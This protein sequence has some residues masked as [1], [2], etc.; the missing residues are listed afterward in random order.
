ML[1]RQ[2]PLTWAASAHPKNILS[3]NENELQLVRESG[4]S[5]ILIGA[6]SGNQAELD[7]IKKNMTT[8]DVLAAA[9]KLAS[10]NI[11]GSFTIM[12]GYPGFS[13][14]NADKTLEFGVR[15]ANI[16]PIHEVKAH[17][18]A[19]YPGTPL[20][21]DAIKAGFVPPRTLEDWTNYDY[22]EVQTPWLKKDLTKKVREFNKEHCP[23]VL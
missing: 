19:P 13:E 6:E 8:E 15:I 12:V 4:C 5:R 16:S 21:T 14:D 22:Y 3:F 23:Y 17:I 9:E 20:Y 18:Y 10:H 1:E 11:R 7:Y 2:L